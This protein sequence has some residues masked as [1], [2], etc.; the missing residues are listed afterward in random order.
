MIRLIKSQAWVMLLVYLVIAAG[1]AIASD[2]EKGRSYYNMQ[3]VACHGKNGAGITPDMPNF[4][5]G[6]G[7]WTSDTQLVKRI[8]AGKNGCPPYLGI[9]NRQKIFDLISY[10]RTF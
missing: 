1:P 5:R 3:C 8:E 10:L 9:L 4:H 2:P 7:L 6:D